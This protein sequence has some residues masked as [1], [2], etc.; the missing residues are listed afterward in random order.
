MG[1]DFE[2]AKFCKK[3]K[4]RTTRE[5]RDTESLLISENTENIEIAQSSRILVVFITECIFYIVD[6]SVCLEI[7][8]KKFPSS[9]Q[10]HGFSFI[11][12]DP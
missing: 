12:I 10:Y 1:M 7:I 8:V 4:R 11:R 5:N 6:M 9:S 2:V 3:L